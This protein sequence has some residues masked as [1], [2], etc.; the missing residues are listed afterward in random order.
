[1]EELGVAY[2]NNS[3]RAAGTEW[4]GIIERDRLNINDVLY[5]I[6]NED[7]EPQTKIKAKIKM[8]MNNL[9]GWKYQKNIKFGGRVVSGFYKL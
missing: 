7:P 1:M 4:V 5:E 6:F 8:Y 9:D 2:K 3:D